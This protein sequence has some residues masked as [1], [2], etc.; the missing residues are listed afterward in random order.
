MEGALCP[1]TWGSG[2]RRSLISLQNPRGTARLGKA[3]V[4]ALA[5]PFH[6][7]DRVPPP[8]GPQWGSAIQSGHLRL[9]AVA[10]PSQWPCT[11]PPAMRCSQ[12][13]WAQCST[14][15]RQRGRVQQ[16]ARPGDG[17]DLRMALSPPQFPASTV[18]S[19]GTWPGHQSAPQ[20]Q[21]PA[22]AFSARPPVVSTTVALDTR[23]TPE[24]PAPPG[25]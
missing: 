6:R 21:V 15:Q 18:P 8:A 14:G 4:R 12:E 22:P 10:P 3:A 19:K 1:G 17:L 2:G 13:L 11:V 20:P 9:V 16:L 5:V 7:A 23:Q 25:G 24:E